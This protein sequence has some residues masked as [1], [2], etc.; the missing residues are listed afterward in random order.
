MTKQAKKELIERATCL[1]CKKDFYCDTD[2]QLC[3]K[4]MKKFDVD[5]L[6]K[7]HDKGELDA[8]DFNERASIRERFRLKG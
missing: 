4:C 6:W 3:P 1:E 7:L 8:L 5:K 2:L